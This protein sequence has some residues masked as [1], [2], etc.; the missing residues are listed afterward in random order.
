VR[1]QPCRKAGKQ[2]SNGDGNAGQ[3]G[4]PDRLQFFF[5]DCSVP[6]RTSLRVIPQTF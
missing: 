3:A 2:D 6:W 5:A 1:A 4:P